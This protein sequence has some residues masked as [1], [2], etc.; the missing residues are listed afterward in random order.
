MNKQEYDH[1]VMHAEVKADCYSSKNFDQIKKHFEIYCD[2]DMDSDTSTD[3]IVIKLSDLPP[4]A[5]ISV[6]YPCCPEC[7]LPREDKF[8]QI[9]GGALKIVG[10]KPKCQCGF[11]WTEW[12]LNKYS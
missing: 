9:G 10:H 6:T 11:N 2:G 5:R 1:Q 8:K 3:D 4:G 7:S 12:V